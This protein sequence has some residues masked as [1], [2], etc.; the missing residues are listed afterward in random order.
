M[1]QPSGERESCLSRLCDRSRADLAELAWLY[2]LNR[3]IFMKPCREEEW[4]LSVTHTERAIDEYV[5][6]F[7][8]LTRDL[9]A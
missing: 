3:R 2:N 4:T 8:E 5:A 6:A 1:R 9:T 7:E